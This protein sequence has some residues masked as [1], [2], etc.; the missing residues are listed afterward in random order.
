MRRPR[1]QPVASDPLA[2]PTAQ[3]IACGLVAPIGQVVAMGGKGDRWRFRTDA[4]YR[5]V[6]AGK[7]APVD[8]ALL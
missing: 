1:S 3:C 7:L 4:C 8:G 6:M 5:A 2:I